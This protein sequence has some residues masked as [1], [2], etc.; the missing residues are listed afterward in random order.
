MKKER[1]ENLNGLRAYACIGII[2]MHVLDNGKYGMNGFVFD[3]FIFSFTN[4][5]FLFMIISAFSMC[6][7]YYKKFQENTI[8]LEDFYRRR[9]QRIWPFFA[10]LCTVELIIDHSLKSLYEWF[11]DLTLAFG[12]IPNHDISVV[13]VGW[14]LGTIFVFYMG[15]PFFVFLLKNKRRAWFVFMITI[16]LHL[17]C[18]FYFTNTG[19]RT[20]IIYSSMFFAAG[21]LLYLYREKL[22]KLRIPAVIVLVFSLLFYFIVN[23]S[24]I[25]T[26]V[27]F[28]LMAICGIA[29]DN[30]L[31]KAAFQNK[32]ITFLGSISMEMYLC[33]M[34]VFRTIDKLKLAH[35][36]A[37][38]LIN[39]FASSMITIGGAFVTAFVLKKLIDFAMKK[40]VYAA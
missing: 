2:L 23:N 40:I 35:I 32:I 3:T 25:T 36:T 24:D 14:F 5:T 9:Y 16:A 22:G 38:P 19:G 20:N 27:V 8:S 15:F 4:F 13:G 29:F 21:G 31:T 33:H 17:L 26:L 7:G 18:R 34:F 1:Y 37:N 28:S 6:C 12:L 30:R 11:A 39:Y 10:S